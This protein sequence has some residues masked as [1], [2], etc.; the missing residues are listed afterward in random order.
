V[1]A[2]GVRAQQSAKLPIIGFMGASTPSAWSRWVAAFEQQLRTRGWIDGRTVAIGYRWAEGRPERLA[3]MA[4][5]FVR[6]KVWP[7]PA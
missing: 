5:E 4:L 7:S 1:A 6:L 2:R 3:E